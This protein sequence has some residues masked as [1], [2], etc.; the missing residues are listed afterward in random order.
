MYAVVCTRCFGYQL[1]T[2]FMAPFADFVN[3]NHKYETS[4]ML[5]NKELHID[6]MKHKSYFKGSKYLHDVTMMY[7]KKETE[8]DREAL[9]NE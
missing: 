5:V 1:E 4:F 9:E 7:E 2:T 8:L 3:H 6:P